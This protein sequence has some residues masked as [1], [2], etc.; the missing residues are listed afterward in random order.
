MAI[1]Y[2]LLDEAYEEAAKLYGVD[3]DILR[4]IG[5][6]ESRFNPNT[7]NSSAG[8]I[9]LMQFL[10]G[11]AKEVGIDPTDPVQSIFGAAAYLRK[12]LDRF[13]GDYAQA[14]AGYNW[15]PNREG[16]QRPD[17]HKTL[18]PATTQYVDDV[19]KYATGTHEKQKYAPIQPK[20]RPI[21]PVEGEPVEPQAVPT[22]APAPQQAQPQAKPAQPTAEEPLPK[23]SL[24]RRAG[25][26]AVS[27]LQI[28]PEAVKG[29]AQVARLATG[30]KF[31]FA[32]DVEQAMERGQKAIQGI[33]GSDRYNEQQKRFAQV[34]ADPNKGLGDM[35][36]YLIDN[37]AVLVDKSITTLGSMFLPAGVAAGAGRLAKA[38]GAAA[39]LIAK[40][41]TAATI[42]T[43]MAQNAAS[44]YADLEGRTEEERYQGAA[45]SAAATMLMGIAT[46]GG[47]EGE[48]A[49]RMADDVTAGRVSLD[50]AKGFIKKA[51]PSA[52]RE[53]TQ[54]VG[55]EAGDIGG[56]AVATG[57]APDPNQ[58]LKQLGLAGTLGAVVGG[59]VGAL[60][61]VGTRVSPEVEPEATPTRPGPEAPSPA[62]R[63]DAQYFPIDAQGRRIVEEAEAEP[64]VPEPVVRG[65]E[66]TAE[67]APSEV[68]TV[69]VAPEEAARTAALGRSIDSAPAPA[70]G[71]VRMYHGGNPEGVDGPL[72]FTAD[73]RDAVG[74]ASRDPSMSVWY[75]DVPVDTPE[76]GRVGLEPG[77]VAPSRVELPAEWA[78][79]R[80]KLE[81]AP[82]KT[83]PPL[84]AE[85]DV[86]RTL[87]A[88]QI[89]LTMPDIRR[90]ALQAGY[91]E[92]ALK[93]PPGKWWEANVAGK[94]LA[95]VQ[96][97]VKAQPNLL[98][99][100][101]SRAVLLSQLAI[102]DVVPAAVETNEEIAAKLAAREA[103]PAQEAPSVPTTAVPTQEAEGSV[104]SAAVGRRTGA[105]PAVSV[106]TG[107]GV[108]PSAGVEPPAESRVGR[109]AQ[110]P[111]RI[112]AGT[113][114]QP[115]A[116]T[117][118]APAPVEPDT[119]LERLRPSLPE[120]ALDTDL[121]D[122]REDWQANIAARLGEAKTRW[123]A[124]AALKREENPKA[125]VQDWDSLPVE[126][127]YEA[128]KVIQWDALPDERKI[129]WVQ[130]AIDRYSQP[131]AEEFYR[132]RFNQISNDVMREPPKPLPPAK[133]RE[134]NLTYPSLAKAQEVSTQLE[135]RIEALRQERKA[136][137]TTDEKGRTVPPADGTP[138]GLKYDKLTSQITELENRKS[139][140]D[141]DIDIYALRLQQEVGESPKPLP[142]AEEVFGEEVPGP[143]NTE[144]IARNNVNRAYDRGDIDAP[145]AGKLYSMIEAGKAKQA[146]AMLN[147]LRTITAEPG[148]AGAL[149]DLRQ[150]KTAGPRA[151]DFVRDLFSEYGEGAPIPKASYD[152]VEAGNAS[153]ALSVLAQQGTNEVVRE[154]A[155]RI[156]PLLANTR[157]ELV[158][159]LRNPEGKAAAGAA[160]VDGSYIRLDRNRGMDEE[161]LVHEG[162]HAAA[163]RVIAAPE[164][165]LT[166]PQRSGKRELNAVW[167]AARND[168]SIPL[169]G[170]ARS[171][172]SEFASEAM[173][174]KD[175][176]EAL[177]AKTMPETGNLW[178]RFKRAVMRMVGLHQPK[179]MRDAVVDAMDKVF[180][181]VPAPETRT[182]PRAE[183][184]TE[185][186]IAETTEAEP[187]RYSLSPDL[188]RNIQRLPREQQRVVVPAV[189]A[190]S[191]SLS[192]LGFS[193]WLFGSVDRLI[194]T[195]VSDRMATLVMRVNRA[196]GEG[197]RNAAGE[198]KPILQM[199]QAYD[200]DKLGYGLMM[201]GDVTFDP[202]TR[203]VRIVTKEENA[204]AGRTD[205]TAPI[206]IIRRIEAWA[207]AN[208]MSFQKAYEEIL[209]PVYEAVRLKN[210]QEEAA[211]AGGTS[212]V[213]P[214]LSQEFIDQAAAE[215]AVDPELVRI[216]E[217]MDEQRRR[218]IDFG[219]EMGRWTREEGDRLKAATGY[220]PFD[221][222]ER[223]AGEFGREGKRSGAGVA[224][225]GSIPEL[226]GS[227]RHSV[228]N[229]FD[230]YFKTLQ[231][232][233]TEG[234]KNSAATSTLRYMET[235]GLAKDLGT[236]PS[237]VENKAR[238]VS[239]YVDG[240]LH[241]FEVPSR[242]DVMAFRYDTVPMDALRNFMGKVS[243]VFRSTIT[244]V[245][246]FSGSQ[247]VQDAQRMA[248]IS[249]VH[250]VVE[251]SSRAFGAYGSLVKSGVLNAD[252]PIIRELGGMGIVGE[253][254][255]NRQDPAASFLKDIGLKKRGFGDPL[256]SFLGEAVHRLDNITTASDAAVRYAVYKQIQKET[257]DQAK[258]INAARELINF[259]RQGSSRLI[260]DFLIPS[261]PFFNAKTQGT[262]LIYR[263]L[264]GRDAPSGLT[265]SRAIGMLVQR[266]AQFMAFSV[267][268]TL[269]KAGDDDYEEVDL[270]ERDRSWMIG[271][272]FT[273]PVPMEHAII[274]KLLPEYTLE[275]FRRKGEPDEQAAAEATIT[276]FK[277]AFLTWFG[278][279]FNQPQAIKAP[280]ENFINFSFFT[281]RP[282]VG[283]RFKNIDPSEQYTSNTSEFAKLVAAWAR[284]TMGAQ[285]S[286]LKID[287]FVRG[288]FGTLGAQFSMVTD[289]LLNPDKPARPLHRIIGLGAFTYDA[290]TAS[291][292]KNEFYKFHE[293]ANRAHQTLALIG[294]RGDAAKYKRYR[295][296]MRPLLA[297]YVLT[298][299]TLEKLTEIRKRINNLE[300]NKKLIQAYVDEAR[301]KGL[302]NPERAG[303]ER[304][305][306]DIVAQ[307]GLEKEALVLVRQQI[308]H[309]NRE[310]AALKKRGINLDA[311]P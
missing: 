215:H 74:W 276:W 101:G 131:Q 195:Q 304:R 18:P 297:S 249:G 183:V 262:D 110:L 126:R 240:I 228:K 49:R 53:A 193:E 100:S 133:T 37:P 198:V 253:I 261:I 148:T 218:I 63:Y 108:E 73:K 28:G 46:K 263:G 237:A 165:E 113:K 33:L 287:N 128:A 50:V 222:L 265:R 225:F 98:K 14:L 167:A 241:F 15:G 173:S 271:G 269:L 32:K 87:P 185:V 285:V 156:A 144:I 196:E 29:V 147:R 71:M 19:L 288:Y 257:G 279:P 40:A 151:V 163:E 211:A 86:D 30:D 161:T 36:E 199:R 203:Q 180:T 170:V 68:E 27:A 252:S 197:V 194:R 284:D 31:E 152:A 72:W 137:T 216:T 146:V 311:T 23:A 230:N 206:D 34:M 106:E 140:A 82:A 219:V 283:E 134:E 178:A 124:D 16:L 11:T 45:V 259:R 280:M 202:N 139:F 153:E 75:V 182:E 22:P 25:D 267:A 224:S 103:Q 223:E 310:R 272:G 291:R 107:A 38:G 239:A 2:T 278:S 120:A 123:E 270:E 99:G 174:R 57:E 121:R 221:R 78:S 176:Q 309:T 258:A 125:R 264:T 104:P 169:T 109:T 142:P 299:Q 233:M 85:Q 80:Q 162:V 10:P 212:S 175:V 76:L 13:N 58:A 189:R 208:N 39:P 26:V 302:P 158:E 132:K 105:G 191:D 130:A 47:A 308:A 9:G 6:A 296:E 186:E 81:T 274:F 256:T 232:L 275:Y 62:Q 266:Y 234:V 172:V 59:G 3:S 207:K 135:S 12:G 229:V 119:E 238:T 157:A 273:L 66:P 95:E 111:A 90:L 251:A 214:H 51:I 290:D 48:I 192:D 305:E 294:E 300:G 67:R 64:E 88:D 177:R 84:V 60:P 7:K 20:L 205:V 260:T 184:G 307:K 226:K 301:A 236:N 114:T 209:P 117:T 143:K 235:L 102:P 4:G 171:D 220:V 187:A 44:T 61:T 112:D 149:S 141:R 295:E 35:A 281:L 204:S 122:A 247:V 159:D 254:D 70:K 41:T 94:T 268:Y 231:F 293:E 246:T 210:V 42:G 21:E 277:Q 248:I 56:K 136:L 89:T 118:T 155:A 181:A 164:A 289:S 255:W 243:R 286:P 8:A 1:D 116:V 190:A 65:R 250:N 154:T 127:K 160:A 54:E 92:G 83:E 303:R 200:A 5:F 52:F 79:R 245:P 188:Q 201:H 93:G 24:L 115:T 129:E 69:P 298:N 91:K 138:E 168:R 306:L 244:L 213:I 150:N 55:E 282:I 217:M 179:N 292:L 43:T 145:A 77:M 96:E 97:L 227:A 166:E 17:W 242:Y